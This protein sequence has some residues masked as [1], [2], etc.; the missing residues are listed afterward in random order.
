MTS[1]LCVSLQVVVKDHLDQP[2]NKVK[3]RLVERQLFRTGGASEDLPCSLSSDSQSDGI[4]VFICNTPSEGVRALLK[5]RGQRLLKTP[6][7]SFTLIIYLCVVNLLLFMWVSCFNVLIFTCHLFAAVF[8][9]SC[10]LC[11]C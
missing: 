10:C 7:L 8:F 1:D 6:Q 11:C 3:V 2:V 4:A 9:S 5:V